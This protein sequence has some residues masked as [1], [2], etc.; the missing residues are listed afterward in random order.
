MGVPREQVSLGCPRDAHAGELGLRSVC[1]VPVE[2]E[3]PSFWNKQAAEAIEASFNIQ[4]KIRQA[5]NL[6]L[7]L[8]DGES[9]W[10]PW[11]AG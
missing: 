6:I 11:Q 10:H 2:E 7:F 3:D 1:T 4:P 8:G 5:K 9:R